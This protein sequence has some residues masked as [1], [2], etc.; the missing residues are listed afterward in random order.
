MHD[1]LVAGRRLL[2]SRVYNGFT[3]DERIAVNPVQRTRR[4]HDNPLVCS[5]SGYSAP[6]DPKG[7]GYMFTHLE[8]YRRPLEWLPVGKRAHRLL[9]ARFVNPRDWF[10]FV[11][12]HYV[13]GAW[14]TML[15]MSPVQCARPFDRCYPQGLPMHEE[16]WE[17]FATAAGLSRDL[18]RA[19]DIREPIR[20]L[21]KFP[22]VPV[23]AEPVEIAPPP[24]RRAA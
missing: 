19:R 23:P 5:I 6:H 10:D 8:D 14:W 13:H 7:S 2:D 9:H 24:R 22:T 3:W 11:A 4:R 15:V 16:R 17:A 1:Y 12:E 20:A 21:W 18:F